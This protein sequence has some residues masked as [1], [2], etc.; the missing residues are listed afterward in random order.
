MKI[1]ELIKLLNTIKKNQPNCDVYILENGV[2]QGALIS[3]LRDTVP[4]DFTFESNIQKLPI[5]SQDQHISGFVIGQ[6]SR[7]NEEKT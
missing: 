6:S 2:Q 4:Q 7:I 1:E 3:Y 5:Y